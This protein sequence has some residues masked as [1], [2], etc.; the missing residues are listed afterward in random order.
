MVYNITSFYGSSC[1]NNG[2]DALNTPDGS[3]GLY[4]SLY[5]YHKGQAGGTF[6]LCRQ[7]LH[8]RGL[9]TL[10]RGPS[11]PTLYL[12]TIASLALFSFCALSRGVRSGGRE[13]AEHALQGLDTD[14][15]DLKGYS[16]DLKGYSAD[17]WRP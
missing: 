15:V 10:L 5:N 6:L 17:I 3:Y 14:S 13:A 1:A 11:P 7:P 8:K 9:A 12:Y 2:K 16:V 4:S